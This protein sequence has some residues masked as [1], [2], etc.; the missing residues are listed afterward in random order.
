MLTAGVNIGH[1]SDIPGWTC[2]DILQLYAEWAQ[3]DLLPDDSRDEPLIVEVGV[4]YGRSFAFLATVMRPAARLVAVDTFSKHL[5][6]QSLPPDV[7]AAMRERG[8]PRDVFERNVQDATGRVCGNEDALLVQRLSFGHLQSYDLHAMPSVD[9]AKLYAD[10][11]V[12]AVF[13]DADHT[14]QACKADIQAWLPKVKP[15]GML[16][17]HDYSR[18][19]HPGVVSAVDEVLSPPGPP[20]GPHPVTLHG[21]V[22]RH[23]V[24]S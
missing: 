10:K 16:A 14:W 9:A 19:N 4:A 23:R 11:S 6:R 18:N 20:R 15:G 7:Y 13:I 12:D 24:K 17:G 21:V 22:W 3:G 1:W 8:S 5:G 2:V